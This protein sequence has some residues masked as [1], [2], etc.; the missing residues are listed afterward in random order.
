MGVPPNHPILIGFSIINQP[1]WDTPID[2]NLHMSMWVLVPKKGTSPKHTDSGQ[3]TWHRSNHDLPEAARELRCASPNR[4]CEHLNPPQ[5]SEP[6][7]PWVKAPRIRPDMGPHGLATSGQFFGTIRPIWG[8]EFRK[9][10][11]KKIVPNKSRSSSFNNKPAEFR[12]Y[13]YVCFGRFQPPENNSRFGPV[14]TRKALDLQSKHG[15]RSTHR[16]YRWF[17]WEHHAACPNNVRH[18]IKVDRWAQCDDT[19]GQS[20]FALDITTAVVFWKKNIPFA[21][22]ALLNLRPEHMIL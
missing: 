3:V 8:H 20:S 22:S 2:G 17:A 16:T 21:T 4:W 6:W 1:F 7:E 5:P 14:P 9:F 12:M 19:Q 11:E 15:L 10:P 18:R 13:A